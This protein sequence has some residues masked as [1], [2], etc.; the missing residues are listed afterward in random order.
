MKRKK[1][2]SFLEARKLV[3]TYMQESKYASVVQSVDTSNQDIKYLTLVEKLTQLEAN[4]WLMFQEK[5]E[6]LHSA[7]CY[8]APVNNRFGMERASILL[9]KQKPT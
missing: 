7:D 9:T 5:L 8:R 6:K 4:D 3:G 1:K 2:M